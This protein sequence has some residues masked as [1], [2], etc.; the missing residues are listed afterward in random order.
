MSSS[1]YGLI[2]LWVRQ[3]MSS[4]AYEFMSSSAYVFASWQVDEFVCRDAFHLQSTGQAFVTYNT[5]NV[6]H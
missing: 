3:L 5:R 4:S 6:R 1:V 2:S